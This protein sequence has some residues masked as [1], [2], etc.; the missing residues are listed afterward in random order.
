MEHVGLLEH[1]TTSYR[2][3]YEPSP[4]PTIAISF[5]IIHLCMSRS[6]KQ[7]PPSGYPT[8]IMC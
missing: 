8:K 5:N 4:Y 7:S 2:K 1:D 6:F 3:Q